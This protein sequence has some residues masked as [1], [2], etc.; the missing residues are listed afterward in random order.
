M[1]SPSSPPPYPGA[2]E[3]ESVQYITSEPEVTSLELSSKDRF[4]IL[5]TDGVWEQVSKE[6]AIRCI[7]A[8][9]PPTPVASSVAPASSG[10]PISRSHRGKAMITSGAL[11]DYVLA[12]LAQGHGMAVSTLKAL[13]RGPL[14]RVLHDDICATVV[15]FTPP[16]APA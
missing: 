13:P 2:L 6:Q 9:M 8:A 10:S 5:V 7:S 3:Q 11:V 15:H 4:L 14:R 16:V 12:R 1:C